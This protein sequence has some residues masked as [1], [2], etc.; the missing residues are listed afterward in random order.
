MTDYKTEI[1]STRIKCENI[2]EEVWNN[3]E[4]YYRT[5][6]GERKMSESLR[7]MGII[8]KVVNES[9]N[10]FGR[11]RRIVKEKEYRDILDELEDLYEEITYNLEF[12]QKYRTLEAKKRREIIEENY[13]EAERIND[14]IIDMV[15]SDIEKIS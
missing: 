1:D 13:E 5:P 2:F 11:V 7:K 8:K 12:P 4:E 14:K 10:K 9:L 3:L 6:E 15:Q